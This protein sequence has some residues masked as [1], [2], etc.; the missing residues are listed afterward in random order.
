MKIADFGF[1]KNIYSK[2]MELESAVGTP[3]FMSFV[4]INFER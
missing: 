3:L 2:K 4:F 1:A